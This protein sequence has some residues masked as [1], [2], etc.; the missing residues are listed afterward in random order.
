[1]YNCDGCTTCCKTLKI[2]ELDKP[3]N[4]W[5][6]HCKIGVGCGIYDSRPE[7]CR[8]Y[9]CVWLQTQ[10]LDKPIPLALRPDKSR[11]LIGTTNQGEDVVLYVSPERPDAWK[12]REFS[13]L[14][15]E[16]QARGIRVMVSCGD[17]LHRI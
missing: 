3:G 13:G 2:R 11:V 6:Q 16:F 5:C 4:T 15:A 7:S 10:R 8:V 12:H 17:T 9:E 14:L 1:M